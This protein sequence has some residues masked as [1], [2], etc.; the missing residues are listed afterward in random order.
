MTNTTYRTD[1]Y[2]WTQEQVALLEAEDW[3]KLDIANLKEEIEDMG[4]S[5]RKELDSRLTTILEHMLKLTCEPKSRATD[6]WRRTILTQRLALAKHL[7]E[8]ATLRA[9]V[10]DFVAD[11]YADAR[12]LAAAGT[13]CSVD[14][15]PVACPWTAK[16]IQDKEFLP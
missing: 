2:A 11:A 16:Q 9:I 1:F 6:K 14:S 4:I 5:Q 13:R 7:K 3:E 10:T 12:E 8:N 15:F